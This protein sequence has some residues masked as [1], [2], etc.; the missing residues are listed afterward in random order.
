M[1]YYVDIRVISSPEFSDSILM[2]EIFA[3]LHRVLVESGEGE[4]GVSFPNF[5]KSL[6]TLLRLHGKQ[7]SLQRIMA[8]HW[9][10][11]LIDYVSLSDI[12]VIPE[13][14]NYRVVKRVQSKS[15]LERLLRRSIRKGWITEEEAVIK[16]SEGRDKKLSLPCLRLKSQSTGQMFQLFVEH[17]PIITAPMVGAFTA[18]GLSSNATIPWF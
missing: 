10:G 14:V 8:K 9:I 6:G 15:N 17:G 4:V 7:I 18:Y 11:G 16:M 1:N 3:R 2:N 13:H 5:T 12:S